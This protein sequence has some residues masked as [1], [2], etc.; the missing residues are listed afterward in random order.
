MTRTLIEVHSYDWSGAGEHS[1]PQTGIVRCAGSP[2]EIPRLE[3]SWSRNRVLSDLCNA[4][5]RASKEGSFLVGMDFAFSFPLAE[6]GNQFP[7]GSTPRA[8]FW[9]RV[10]DTVWKDRASGYVAL[11]A[12]H[13]LSYDQRA[14]KTKKG[15]AY[16]DARRATERAAAEANAKPNTV[17]KLVGS[18]QVGKGSLCG[19]A[20]LEELRRHCLKSHLPLAVWPFFVLRE[21]GQEIPM[22]EAAPLKDVPEK[23]PLVVETYPSL[24]WAQAGYATRRPWNASK[25]WPDVRSHFGAKP[26][27]TEASS[28]DEGDALITWYALSGSRATSGNPLGTAYLERRPGALAIPWATIREEG[29]I[30]G[31]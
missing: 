25:I 3:G 1:Q 9:A 13:F 14:K 31:L 17:F 11:H 12:A 10:H 2:G 8:D 29:W 20:L 23:C 24:H 22:T 26:A 16:K 21:D 15:I 4:A 7:D 18:N 6:K 5:E 30:Y 27:R 28:G 19:I